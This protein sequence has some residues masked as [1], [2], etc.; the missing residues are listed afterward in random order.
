[1]L[2]RYVQKLNCAVSMIESDCKTPIVSLS[3]TQSS[4]LSQQVYLTDKIDNPKRD[5]MPHL[6]C[7]C[8][9]QP[10]EESLSA[11]E[12]ELREPKY[13]DYYLCQSVDPELLVIC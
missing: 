10:T 8:F 2:I 4:L 5:R 7:V 3:A 12:N 11:L 1:M 13:G 9:L 6:K